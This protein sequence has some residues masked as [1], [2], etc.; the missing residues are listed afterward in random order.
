[1]FKLW[2]EFCCNQKRFIEIRGGI[3]YHLAKQF[4]ISSSNFGSK[5]KGKFGFGK[6]QRF[7][8]RLLSPPIASDVFLHPPSG[9][10]HRFTSLEERTK[11]NKLQEMLEL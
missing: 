5:L 1:M 6:G 10:Q 7:F 2:K 8:A 9:L 11:R 3:G 4:P